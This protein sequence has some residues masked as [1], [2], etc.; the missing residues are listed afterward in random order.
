MKAGII[1]LGNMG[2]SIAKRLATQNIDLVLYN[3]TA[4]KAKKLAQI[5]AAEYVDSPKAMAKSGAEYVAIFVSDDPA[6]SS[7]LTSQSGLLDKSLKATVVNM[8]TVTPSASK[9]V[10]DLLRK[11]GLKYI[12]SPVFATPDAIEKG[13]A[14]AFL[15]GSEENV[16]ASIEFIKLFSS[17]W[18]HV[19]EIPKAA[20]LKLAVNGMFLAFTSLIA[21][22]GAT[23]KA[24]NVKSELFR[25]SFKQ[26]W[27]ESA[28]ET[29]WK[30]AYEENAPPKFNVQLAEKELRYLAEAAAEKGLSMHVALAAAKTYNEA[31]E[32]S[33][34]YYPRAVAEHLLNR[35]KR[36]SKAEE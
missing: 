7:V 19:G 32:Y 11:N 26:T 36:A 13:L 3:R 23:L 33:N 5:L 8:S 25:E 16:N 4:E 29:V 15:G 2:S 28:L 22:T 6:F 18:F 21:E 34:M 14:T 12:E 31:R 30:R 17:K 9:K 1:G 20:V 35:A 24:W 10:G 27:F